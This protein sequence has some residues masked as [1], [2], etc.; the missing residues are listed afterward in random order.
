ML[1][2]DILRNVP[3]LVLANKQ[4]LHDAIKP[5]EMTNILEVSS[6]R[7]RKWKVM[8]CYENR[9]KELYEGLDWLLKNINRNLK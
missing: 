5:E 9:A 3:L 6:I 2:E 8:E 4:E 1:N 7:N